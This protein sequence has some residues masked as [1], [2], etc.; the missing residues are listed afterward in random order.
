MSNLF[1]PSDKN[2]VQDG[3][4]KSVVAVDAN[5]AETDREYWDVLLTKVDLQNGSYGLN[6][7]YRYFKISMERNVLHWLLRSGC[8]S[9]WTPSKTCTFWLYI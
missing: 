9:Y 5:L 7:F 1:I 6:N 3:K 8:K 2:S 4:F